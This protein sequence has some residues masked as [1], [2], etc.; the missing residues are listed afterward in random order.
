MLKRKIEYKGYFG[1]NGPV[2][3]KLPT[4]GNEHVNEIVWEV[5]HQG[6]FHFHEKYVKHKQKKWY[7]SYVK[8]S[9]KLQTDGWL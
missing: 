4:T 2:R 6:I 7:K 8:V 1:L 9:L 3:G 5:R